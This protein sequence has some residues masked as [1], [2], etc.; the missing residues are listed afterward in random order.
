M[1]EFLAV[2]CFSCGTHQAQQLTKSSRFSCPVCGEK[3]SVK[4]VFLRSTRAAECRSVVQQLNGQR[5]EE[6]NACNNGEESESPP[7]APLRQPGPTVDWEQFLEHEEEPGSPHVPDDDR[8]VTALPDA[9]RRG[10]GAGGVVPSKKRAR[11]AEA[12]CT[13]DQ[14]LAAPTGRAR[15]ASARAVRPAPA[16][17]TQHRGQA[18]QAA[19]KTSAG[20]PQP[21]SWGVAPLR[22]TSAQCNAPSPAATMPASA[23]SGLWDEFLDLD[24]VEDVGGGAGSN[25]A[26]FVTVL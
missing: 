7:R 22:A 17:A 20:R 14:W 15:R 24:A 4:Q 6:E 16:P 12:A 5:Q 8:F 19:G 13:K 25:E 9:R 11:A 26:G 1:P 10:A 2:R 23:A 21:S 3:Q 18:Q